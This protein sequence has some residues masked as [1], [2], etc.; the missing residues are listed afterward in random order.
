MIIQYS[1]LDAPYI[2]TNVGFLQ[3]PQLIYMVYHRSTLSPIAK[4]P[5]INQLMNMITLILI[6]IIII[7]CT[8]TKEKPTQWP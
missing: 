6:K 2:G 7:I 4:S 1:S 8:W 5:T 3:C